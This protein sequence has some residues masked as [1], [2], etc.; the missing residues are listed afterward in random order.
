[1]A[2]EELDWVY[3]CKKILLADEQQ[4]PNGTD[5]TIKME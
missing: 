5:A 1:M 3:M 4:T 2:N